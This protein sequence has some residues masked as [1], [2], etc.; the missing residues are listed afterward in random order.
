METFRVGY[1]QFVTTYACKLQN[2]IL[3]S[4]VEKLFCVAP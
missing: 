4:R 3:F 2:F 1:L